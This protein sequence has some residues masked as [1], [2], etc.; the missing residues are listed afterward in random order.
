MFWTRTNKFEANMRVG[1]H[2]N[3]D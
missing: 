3:H 2:W 1:C